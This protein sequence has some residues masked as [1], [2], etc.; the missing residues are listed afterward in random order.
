M[1]NGRTKKEKLRGEEAAGHY[2][3]DSGESKNVRRRRNRV[4]KGNGTGAPSTTSEKTEDSG[5]TRTTPEVG[6]GEINSLLDQTKANVN[7]IYR[8]V[9][10]E[11]GEGFHFKSRPSRGEI[12]STPIVV[13]YVLAS[14]PPFICSINL[15]ISLLRIT[16]HT[17]LSPP[18]VWEIIP[19]VNPRS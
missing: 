4:N 17:L 1:D 13:L 18:T 5:A 11:I 9:L 3:N 10:D 15:L 6:H 16:A 14:T 12:F 8:E 7:R 19:Q 2:M